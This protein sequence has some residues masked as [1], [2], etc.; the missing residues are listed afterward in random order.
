MQEVGGIVGEGED[1]G[2]ESNA[3]PISLYKL[4]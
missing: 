4:N 1:D 2:G 3:P